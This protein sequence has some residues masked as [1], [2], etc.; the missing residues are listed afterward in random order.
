MK[1]RLTAALFAFIALSA[2]VASAQLSEG[3][4]KAAARAAYTEGVTLQ[5]KG[6]PAE[7]L[8]RFEAAEKLF[9]APTHLLHIAECQALTGRLVEASE[10]YETLIRKSYGKD[11]PEVFLQAQDQGRAELAQLKPRVPTM[12]VL[13]KPDPQTLQSCR[14]SRSRSTTSSSPP[15]S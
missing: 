6:N 12:R 7:A 11:A 14:V 1:L 9:D 3:E 8:A 4:R 5:E 10:T 15:S 2:S 13:V